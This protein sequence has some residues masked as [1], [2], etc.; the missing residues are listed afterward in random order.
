[1]AFEDAAAAVFVLLGGDDNVDD[2][3]EVED[4]VGDMN[5]GGEFVCFAVRFFGKLPPKQIEI[6]K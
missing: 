4:G 3:A 5:S 6:L 2:D 1:M